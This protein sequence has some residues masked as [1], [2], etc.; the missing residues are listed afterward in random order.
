MAEDKIIK[1]GQLTWPRLFF[2]VVCAGI[3]FIIITTGELAIGYLLVTAALCLILLFV[4]IDYRVKMPKI[5][6]KETAVQPAPDLLVESQAS[7]V[8]TAVREARPRR[9]SSRPARRRR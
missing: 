8:S 3:F 4:M 2:L 1:T 6:K 9:R 7:E 5:E